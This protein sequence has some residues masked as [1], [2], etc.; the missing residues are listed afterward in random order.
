[1]NT[2]EK[3]DSLMKTRFKY[4]IFC[5]IL[6][7][8]IG[9]SMIW[10]IFQPY[11]MDLT[12]WDVDTAGAAYPIAVI[13]FVLGGIISGKLQER[14]VPRV[15]V[16]ISG[17]MMG[18]GCVLAAFT[19]FDMPVFFY[20][21]FSVICGLGWGISY[22]QAIALSQKWFYDKRGF[23]GGVVVAALGIAAMITTPIASALFTH[24]SFKLA[25]IFWG[26][27]F[28]LVNIVSAIFIKNPPEGFGKDKGGDSAAI[29]SAKQYT[30][31]EIL[32]TP[33][34][35][36]LFLCMFCAC[37]SFYIIN[38]VWALI[39]EGKGVDMTLIVTGMMIAS[40]AN[41]A[42]RLVASTLSDRIGRKFTVLILYILICAA[43]LGMW[44]L[45]GLWIIPSFSLVCF[46]YGGFLATFP[47]ITTDYYGVKHAGTNY[48]LVMIGMGAASVISLVI[49]SAF[50]RADLPLDM[51]CLPAAII[52]VLGVVFSLML[53]SVKPKKKEK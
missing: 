36:I 28:L 11:V 53:K 5:G 43:C 12:G 40:I 4:L 9:V 18:A 45:P 41:S 3:N 30:P 17:V 8:P 46:C 48:G 35:Y 37:I 6:Q 42:G 47:A 23:A 39:G 22:N 19:P 38:P 44:K 27:I 24:F 49:A 20:I 14:F 33:L 51:R 29:L 21:T 7:I 10:G 13:M 26:A 31:G 34:Y 52:A 15:V 1:M 25:F 16:L 2:D 32:K 50:T